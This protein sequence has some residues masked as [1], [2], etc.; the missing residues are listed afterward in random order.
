MR[1]T[2]AST[3]G[4]GLVVALPAE[5]HSLG[6]RGMRVGECARWRGGWVAI[7]GIGADNAARAAERLLAYGIDRLA[8]WGVAGALDPALATRRRVDPRPRTAYRS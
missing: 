4:I 8:N 1:K 5:A 2:E 6:I 7:S 3:D